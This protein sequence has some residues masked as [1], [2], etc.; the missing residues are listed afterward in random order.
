MSKLIWGTKATEGNSNSWNAQLN[1]I[2]SPLHPSNIPVPLSWALTI[3]KRFPGLPW[4]VLLLFLAVVPQCLAPAPRSRASSWPGKQCRFSRVSNSSANKTEFSNTNTC[5]ARSREW[6]QKEKQNK[7]KTQKEDQQ[8]VTGEKVNEK[9]ILRANDKV[10]L[11]HSVQ[12]DED[13]EM[14]LLLSTNKSML[15]CKCCLSWRTMNIAEYTNRPWATW[16]NETYH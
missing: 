4:P 12:Q 10:R 8:K 5:L 7:T 11:G 1:C 15:S 9:P 2:S 3:T 16:G 13:Q 6:K 14:I